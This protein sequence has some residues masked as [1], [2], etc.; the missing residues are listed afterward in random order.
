MSAVCAGGDRP[1][2][3]ADLQGR[4]RL[5]SDRGPATWASQSKPSSLASS[6]AWILIRPTSSRVSRSGAKVSV[7]ATWIER[8]TASDF[9]VV[10][11]ACGVRIC[12]RWPAAGTLPPSQVA[13]ADQVPLWP[14]ESEA[15]IR[16]CLP[17]TRLPHTTSC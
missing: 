12:T 11:D 10:D 2:G 16:S 13:A 3:R 17:L 9:D 4:P 5:H 1:L 7:P 6:P 15:A 8:I 14:C